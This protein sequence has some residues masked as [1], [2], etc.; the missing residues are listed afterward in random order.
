MPQKMNQQWSK[1][2]V[3]TLQNGWAKETQ[4]HPKSSNINVEEKWSNIKSLQNDFD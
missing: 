4:V 3:Y 2:L 1:K